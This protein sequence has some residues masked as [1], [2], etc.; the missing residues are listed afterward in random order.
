MTTPTQSPA[1]CV[2]LRI[3]AYVDQHD[4]GG[5]FYCVIRHRYIVPGRL[6]TCVLCDD[7]DETRWPP[8]KAFEGPEL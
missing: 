8:E 5:G 7:Y 6:G 3:R 2:S 4:A 1:P